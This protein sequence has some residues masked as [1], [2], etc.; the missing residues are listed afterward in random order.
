[1]LIETAKEIYDRCW[2][3]V[4][5]FHSQKPVDVDFIVRHLWRRV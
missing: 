4:E 1:M 2:L 3:Q 5:L